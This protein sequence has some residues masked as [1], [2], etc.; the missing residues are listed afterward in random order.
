[1]IMFRRLWKTERFSIVRR[2][3]SVSM[4]HHSSV[5]LASILMYRV[6]HKNKAT[7]LDSHTLKRHD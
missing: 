5:L 7:L 1:M 3:E 4:I 6:T 2:T